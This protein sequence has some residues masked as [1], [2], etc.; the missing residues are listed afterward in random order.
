[1]RLSWPAL[2]FASEVFPITLAVTAQSEQFLESAID[3]A[4]R[5]ALPCAGLLDLHA[6]S[7]DVQADPESPVFRLH[8]AAEGLALLTLGAGAPGPVQVC[9]NAGKADYRRLHGGGAGQLVA[10]AIGLQKAKRPLRVVDATAGLGQDAFVLASLGCQVTLLERVQPV[11]CLLQDGLA[12][13]AL[14][15]RTAAIVARMTLHR[16]DAVAWLQQQ[17]PLDADVIYL[18]PM[19]PHRD[20]SAEV[21]KEMRLFRYLVGQDLDAD[22]LL[23]AALACGAARVVVKRPRKAPALAGPAPGLVIEGKSSR[24]D[25]YPLRKL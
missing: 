16:A 15:E 9:F 18:D 13:A 20:K 17:A 25:I 7:A 22:A 2:I 12:R 3:L 19:F 24:Y 10:K 8:C 23:V 6:R 1:M 4:E 21:K 14:D 11:A 5:L